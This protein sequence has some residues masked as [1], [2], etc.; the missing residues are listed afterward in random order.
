VGNLVICWVC[1]SVVAS[2]SQPAN[3]LVKVPRSM[4]CSSSYFAGKG[5]LS[6]PIC[7]FVIVVMPPRERMLSINIFILLLMI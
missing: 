6:G 1:S 7:Y 5:S 2:G 3:L 4:F